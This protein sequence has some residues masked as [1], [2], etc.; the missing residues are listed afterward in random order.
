MLNILDKFCDDMFGSLQLAID[1]LP[2]NASHQDISKLF[3]QVIQQVYSRHIEASSQI[4]LHSTLS[5]SDVLNEY[6]STRKNDDSEEFREKYIGKMITPHDH[7]SLA[8]VNELAK[9]MLKKV[10]EANNKYLQKLYAHI[11]TQSDDVL[12]IMREHRDA[13]VEAIEQHHAKVLAANNREQ[14]AI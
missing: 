10:F 6:S 13:V 7:Y 1:S 5:E 3:I 4:G 9:D 2:P 11:N 14:T 8:Q 12:T